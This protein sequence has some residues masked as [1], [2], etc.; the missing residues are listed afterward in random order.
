MLDQTQDF[1]LKKNEYCKNQKSVL[2]EIKCAYYAQVFLQVFHL[3]K[4]AKIKGTSIK[5]KIAFY[6]F[7]AMLCKPWKITSKIDEK[8]KYDKTQNR[9]KIHWTSFN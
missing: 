1:F 3:V 4:Y 5:S 9:L 8:T 2:G 7:F 6:K